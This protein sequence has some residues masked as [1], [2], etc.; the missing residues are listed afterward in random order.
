MNREELLDELDRLTLQYDDARQVRNDARRALEPT[1]PT[2]RV[3]ERGAWFELMTRQADR[4]SS[5]ED[6]MNILRAQIAH[7]G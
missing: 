4:M 2:T 6:R 3:D 7:V 1:N 5:T